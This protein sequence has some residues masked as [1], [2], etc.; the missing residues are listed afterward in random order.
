MHYLYFFVFD[1]MEVRLLNV[2]VL[3]DD[4]EAQIAWYKSTFNLKELLKESGAYNYVELGHNK[5]VIVGLTPAKEMKHQPAKARNNSTLLQITVKDMET[6]F[7]KVKTNNGK[8]LFGPSIEEKHNFKYG[9]ITDLEG[10]EIW[11]IE[12]MEK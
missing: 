11:V 8:V 12:E 9:A 2:V 10:N 3:C 7:K 6:L 1:S 5:H 4:F